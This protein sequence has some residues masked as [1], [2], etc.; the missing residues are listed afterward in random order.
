[1]TNSGFEETEGEILGDARVKVSR[2]GNLFLA[3]EGV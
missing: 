3:I 2:L 1:M